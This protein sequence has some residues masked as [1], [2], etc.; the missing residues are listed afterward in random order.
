[1]PRQERPL[2]SED[3]PLLR[4][5]GDLRRLRQRAGRLS[6]RDLGKRTNYSAAALSDALSGRRLPS[7]A[8]TG[9][10]VRACGGDVEEWTGRWRHLATARPGSH[11]GAMPYVGLAAYR[12]TDADRFFGREAVTGTLATMV[13]QR[14]FVG[15]FGSSG[16]GKS[17]L[18]QAGLIARSERRPI[19]ITPGTDPVTELAVAVAD[20]AGEPA[21]LVRRDLADGTGALRDRL[22]RASGEVL[23][24]I[25]QFEE[26]F[27]LCGEADRLWLIRSLTAAAGPGTKV[28]I[29][30]RADFYG[31]C[32]RHPELVTALHRAQVLVGPM[33]TEEFR[34]A[35]TEPATRAGATLETALVARL[36]SDVAGQ[37]AA[38][39]LASHALAET[40]RRRRGMVMTLAGYEDVGGIEH[41]LART[42]EHTFAQLTDDD[43]EAVR[44]VFPRLVVLGDGTGDT[45]RR[46]R[47]T[48]LPIADTLLDRLAT[49]R[50]VTIGRDTVELTHEALLRAWPRL[51]GWLSRDRENLRRRHELAEAAAVWAA[52]AH[53]P[54]TLYRGARL[55]QATE[56]RDRLNP[57]EH[58]F[59]DASLRADTARREADQRNT[60]RLRQ[61]A[62]GLTVL[63]VLLAGTAIVAFSAQYR[64]GQQRNEA[65]SLRAADTA[66]DMIAGHP[67]DAAVLALAAYRLS[68]TGEAR[69][70][71]L[72][73]R[74]AAD[75]TTLG[76][77]YQQPP[78]RY[79][80]TYTDQADTLRLWRRSGVSWRP[81]GRIDAGGGH[82]RTASLDENRAVYWTANTS[83][84]LWD[85][86]DLDHPRKIGL[87]AGLGLV[88]GL[89]RT[90][91]LV[92]AIGSDQTARLWRTGSATFRTL[93]AEDVV[94]ADVLDDG[95]GVVL[96]RREGDQDVIESWTTDGRPVAV[97][98]RVPHPAVVQS[99]PG[100][101]IAVTSYLDG[102]TMTIMDVTDPHSPRVIAHADD[103]DETAA[104]AFDPGGRTVAVVDGAEARIWDARDGRRLL[105]LRTQGLRLTTPRL[106]GEQLRL[107]DAKSA[108][109]H[110]DDDL[111]AVIDR[112]CT[113][114]AGIDWNRYFPD[115]TPIPL[116]PQR[117]TMR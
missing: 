32:A 71:L 51:A 8:I 28:V 101:L 61:L 20:L 26:V 93:S 41:A 43:R 12:V 63:A 84:D 17:S 21:D 88:H 10:V 100:G 78:V 3:T 55:E 75:S 48:D 107:L 72:L 85:L 5:A 22:A 45:K 53:D 99:G 115:T 77:G 105:S 60:R 49:A 74:A 68:P 87:P 106:Q 40:W 66:R 98:S 108:L 110:I 112:T 97:L 117:T 116:C 39:P 4:F 1:M 102:I 6:Y 114:P 69:D 96:S 56:L 11:T 79:A 109:W 104:P 67:Y 111:A 19:L 13:E 62:A 18:L 92:A 81:A 30:V 34:T 113:G 36:I 25:D 38:L 9:A 73:A 64:A 95:S 24:V 15:V 46:V 86:A 91:S 70:V 16:A 27:T 103:L 57:R 31:H 59:L 35:I 90:G 29:G 37:P 54:D 33:S 44:L 50:L 80:A 65:L 23:L 52:N 76:R 47:R 7:L 83:S 89:D 58:A 94:G 82:F 14:P 2:E 42:A